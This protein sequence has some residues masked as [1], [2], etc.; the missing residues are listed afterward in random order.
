MAKEARPKAIDLGSLQDRYQA[1]KRQ[2]EIDAKALER[3]QQTFDESRAA[4]IEAAANLRQAARTVL[5]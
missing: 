1:T 4:Y 5:S 2:H 3:A